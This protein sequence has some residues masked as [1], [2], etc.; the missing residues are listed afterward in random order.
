MTNGFQQ[1]SQQRLLSKAPLVEY[2]FEARWLPPDGQTP[3]AY[4]T[5]SVGV[6]RRHLNDKYPI[7]QD[8]D[9]GGDAVLG[10]RFLSRLPE[11]GHQYSYPLIQY[12]PGLATYNVDGATYSWRGRVQQD[13]VDFWRTLELSHEGFDGLKR[14][15]SLR[16]VDF[17]ETDD[18]IRFANTSLKL[19]MDAEL[20]ESIRQHSDQDGRMELIWTLA[21]NMRL[22]VI[23]GRGTVEQRA[24]LILEMVA[25][26]R[27][28]PGRGA[29]L[30]G[31]VKEQHQVLGDA[32][33]GL[34]TEA[35]HDALR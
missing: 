11:E 4:F 34:I 13:I 19:R 31:M 21:E 32:F 25:F 22:H 15:V 28:D 10:R 3:H 12:R 35:V 23:A 18:A 17:F 29:A 30:E 9:L 2:V 24:G 16:S 33:F 5:D 1:E 20:P 7:A 27:V 14:S 6:L 8:L 26:S